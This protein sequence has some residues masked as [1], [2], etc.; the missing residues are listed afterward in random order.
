MIY[1]TG[2]QHFGHSNIIRFCG[3]PFVTVAEMD[4]TLIKNWNNIVSDDDIV[5]ILGDLL[6]RSD[7]HASYYIDR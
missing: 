4:E 1:Y 3:R 5:Y 7:K 2:D 6:F